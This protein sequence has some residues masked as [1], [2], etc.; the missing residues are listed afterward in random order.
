MKN[1]VVR[2]GDRK[3]VVLHVDDEP[4]ILELTSFI[5]SPCGDIVVEGATSV[6]AARKLISENPPDLILLD[7]MMGGES[8]WDLL[9][10][11]RDEFGLDIPIVILTAYID[12][13]GNPIS[14]RDT[15]FQGTLPK[16]YD[17]ESLRK[18]VR[19]FLPAAG[20]ES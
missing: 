8:G 7:L 9:E 11:V 14:A 4:E 1:N 18:T 15:R 6:T 19:D 10:A 20:G 13:R 12:S 16:P 17:I 5:L 3:Y 2:S